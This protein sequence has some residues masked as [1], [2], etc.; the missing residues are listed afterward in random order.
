MKRIFLNALFLPVLLAALVLSARGQESIVQPAE[1]VVTGDSVN[2]RA[3]A[4][5]TSE[6]VAQLDTGSEVTTFGTVLE[7]VE[8]GGKPISWTKI[9]L[10]KGGSAWV[11]D[12]YLD[13]ETST[14]LPNRLNVRGGPSEAYSVLGR[15][16][17]GTK[18]E[19]LERKDGWASIAPVDG[20]F[21]Y[22]A[23]D[24]LQIRATGK[25]PEP[26]EVATP[27]IDLID[28]PAE[29]NIEAVSNEP[30]VEDQL[31]TPVEVE[32][33]EVVQIDDTGLIEEPMEFVGDDDLGSVLAVEPSG[34]TE[35]GVLSGGPVV[36]PFMEPRGDEG[37]RPR[38]IVRREGIIGGTFSIQ[39]P[40][41]F[42]LKNLVTGRTMN[43]ITTSDKTLKLEDI[44]G[45][46]VILRGEEFIDKRWPK[47]PVLHIERIEELK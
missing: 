20:I 36:A 1:A 9:R 14:V 30:I 4:V 19:V 7:V 35:E 12:R 11:S 8:E 27:M 37:E 25:S 40:S 16:E 33:L 46:H 47:T 31:D 43:Y 18:V 26:F 38:R 2:V 3:R 29:E 10:P 45:R 15:I 28:D 6:V 42:R 23:S 34:L 24:Y 41:Y 22:V 21:G 13:E 17:Q 5:L 44:K 32:P 39:A